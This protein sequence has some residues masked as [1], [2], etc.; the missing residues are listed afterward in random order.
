[1]GWWSW[2]A[3]Y[4]G[5]NEGAAL[6]NAEWEA[7][8]L[9]SYGYNVFH[10]DEGYQYARGEYV[11]PN[12]T[13][14]PRGLGPMEGQIHGLGLTPGIWTA[15]FE[16]SE[17]SWVFQNHPDWLVKN[18][19]GQPVHAGFVD[20]EKDQLYVLDTTNPGAQSYLR[21]TYSR[22]VREWGIRYFKL[23][24]MDDTAIE[25]YYL[26]PN[27]TAMEAQ[28]IGLKVIRDAVGDEVL[29][30]KDGSVMINPVGYVDYGRISQDTG[31][32]FDAS[33]DAVT[34]IAARYFMNRNYFVA[35]PDAFT[36][37]T[38]TIP[39][40]SWHEG[41]KPA[42]LDE[43]R[44]SIALAAVSGGMLEIG[45]N[46]P[47]LQNSQERLAL[48]ENQDLIDMVRLGHASRP[49]DLMSYAPSDSQPSIFFLKE[50]KRQSILTVFNWTEQKT[51]HTIRLAD[52]GL[53]ATAHYSYS[54]VLD[55]GKPAQAASAE[56]HLEMPPHSVRVLKI[57]DRDAAA[58]LPVLHAV[59]PAEAKAG[60]GVAFYVEETSGN[61]VLSYK[62]DFGDGTQLEGNQVNHAWTEPGGYMVHL[63]A[64]GLDSGIASESFR[65]HI[66]GRI[67]TD[68]NPGLNRRLETK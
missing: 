2:T 12:A 44:I 16:V 31:H 17:R 58:Q 68:F 59:H 60:E 55:S 40:Q 51:E 62:W 41:D 67:A 14:F 27:T 25:G 20:D 23:D 11:T 61:P 50:S 64:G 7:Q 30:D 45:D 33:H 3:W 66:A 10:I 43:A 34:G 65:I 15:P 39:D 9:K 19:Q 47:S 36:V 38:Q 24:F 46:L 35:D 1:M 54:D 49:I 48:I 56:I 63:T 6:T 21:E 32:T 52:L 4:F 29:L 57:I 5:L 28:R 22:L 26:K 13:V 42:T 18:A 53:P 8:H 37:S